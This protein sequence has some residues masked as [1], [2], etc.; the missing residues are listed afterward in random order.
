MVNFQQSSI[1][2]QDAAL[3]KGWSPLLFDVS[4]FNYEQ[5]LEIYAGHL[6]GIDVFQYAD[7]AISS[8][9]MA[10]IRERMSLEIGYEATEKDIAE[11][12]SVCPERVFLK[13]MLEQLSGLDGDLTSTKD[14]LGRANTLTV[15]GIAVEFTADSLKNLSVEVYRSEHRAQVVAGNYVYQYDLA[16]ADNVCL[17]TSTR[18]VNITI[19]LDTPGL[20]LI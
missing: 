6:S 5:L 20:I 14:W 17:L 10:V 4:R 13:E 2:V 18:F 11:L 8:D 16:I 3:A 15:A 12:D 7:P 19:K 9:D 1:R